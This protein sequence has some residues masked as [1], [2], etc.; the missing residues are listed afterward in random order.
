MIV[1]THAHLHFEDFENIIDGIF[2]NSLKSG[3]KKIIT[4]GTDDADSRSAL[5]FAQANSKNKY[6]LKIYASAGIHPH[7][8]KLGED[9]LLTIKELLDNPEYSKVLVA[10]GEC[11]LD[12]FKNF[13]SKEEQIIMLKWQLDLAQSYYL[14]VIFHIREAWQDF[15]SIIKDYPKVRGVIHSFTGGE[16]ELEKALDLKL[17]LG[18][19]GIVTFS[20]DEDQI[21]AVKKIP[22]SNLLLETDCPFLSPVPMRGKVNEPSYLTYTLDFLSK[23]KDVSVVNLSNATTENAERLFGI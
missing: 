13:S 7:E 9:G 17:Y 4:V 19:N 3:V 22:L 5:N 15:Y 8:A 18:I 6:G 20:K 12:Y 23:L 10:I 2:Y 11:G 16:A 14:P 21:E 1:D